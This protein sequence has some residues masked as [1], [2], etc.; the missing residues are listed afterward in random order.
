MR[1]WLYIGL[2]GFLGA[3]SR[4]AMSLSVQRFFSSHPFPAG[5]LAVNLLGSLIIGFS[6]GFL[7]HRNCMSPDIRFFFFTGFLGAF[8][9]FST[10]SLENLFL[11][12]EGHSALALLNLA[13]APLLSLAAA[14]AAYSFAR[15]L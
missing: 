2:G 4:H 7:E 8:T 15:T 9:T 1:I 11:F 6:A 10:F 12:R 14:W 5:T 13:A 3:I